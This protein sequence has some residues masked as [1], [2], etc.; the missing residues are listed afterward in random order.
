MS[1]DQ[2]PP[3]SPDDEMDSVT[4]KRLRD[5]L[6][7]EANKS[8]L[9]K[10]WKA[11]LAGRATGLARTPEE[12]AEAAIDHAENELD[13]AQELAGTISDGAAESASFAVDNTAEFLTGVAET[14]AR[15]F[16]QFSDLAGDVEAREEDA[17]SSSEES[18]GQVI[19]EL[20]DDLQEDLFRIANYKQNARLRDKPDMPDDLRQPYDDAIRKLQAEVREI[21]AAETD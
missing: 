14:I 9:S 13:E 2:P 5:Y 15:I 10:A 16:G 17:E 20:P 1:T 8:R 3:P 12:A 18:L 6:K 19:A 4:T 21:D 7:D 11:Y